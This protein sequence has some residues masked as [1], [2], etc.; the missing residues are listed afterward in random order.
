VTTERIETPFGL[1]VLMS[2]VLLWSGGL[3]VGFTYAAVAGEAPF[4]KTLMYGLLAAF[5]ALLAARTAYELVRRL[6]RR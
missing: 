6:R 1:Y 4:S 2:V 5:T 3:T